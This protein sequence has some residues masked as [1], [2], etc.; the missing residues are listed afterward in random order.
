LRF[1]LEHN[2]PWQYDY[3]YAYRS[4]ALERITMALLLNDPWW[5]SYIL[6][7]DLSKNTRATIEFKKLKKKVQKKINI[8]N[9]IVDV[10]GNKFLIKD[11]VIY[12]LA[13]YI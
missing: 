7:L 1:C 10:L 4:I 5:T 13:K 3:P 6:N 2:H 8:R 9:K 12:D 11:I